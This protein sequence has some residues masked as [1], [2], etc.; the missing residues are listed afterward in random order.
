MGLH[1][2]CY[3]NCVFQNISLLAFD[4]KCFP[5]GKGDVMRWIPC[6]LGKLCVEEDSPEKVG[7]SSSCTLSLGFNFRIM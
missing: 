1:L 5:N 3:R 2:Q 6:P 4:A 7:A